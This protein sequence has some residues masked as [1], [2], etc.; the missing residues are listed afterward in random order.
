MQI[1]YSVDPAKLKK[2]GL[3]QLNIAASGNN[4][5]FW[6]KYSGTDPEHSAGGWNPCVDSSQTPRSRSF[7]FSLNFGF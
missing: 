5:I 2:Y 7:T 4:L 1:S 3:S 6:T